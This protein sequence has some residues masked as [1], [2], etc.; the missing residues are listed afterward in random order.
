MKLRQK[1]KRDQA[2]DAVA[3][4]AKTWSEWRLGDKVSKTASQASKKASK[5]AAKA[6]TKAKKQAAKAAGRQTSKRRPVWI[7]GAIALVGGIGVAAA[8][9]F[10]GGK[11]EPLYTPGDPAPD[12]SSPAASDG[13]TDSKATTDVPTTEEPAL[14]APKDTPPRDPSPV[15]VEDLASGGAPAEAESGADAEPPDAGGDSPDLVSGGTG[16]SDEASGASA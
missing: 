7:A 2:L 13:A 14:T 5:N 12:T 11:A 6:S 16:D 1:S 8:K 15:V 3:S 4:I 9:K 10:T